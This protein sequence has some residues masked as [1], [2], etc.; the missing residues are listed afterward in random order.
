MGPSGRGVGLDPIQRMQA[1]S[2][3]GRIICGSRG[4]IAAKKIDLRWITFGHSHLL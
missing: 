2:A 1:Q 4:R 3:S